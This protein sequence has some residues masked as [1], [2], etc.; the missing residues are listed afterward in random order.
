LISLGFLLLVAKGQYAAG[1]LNFQKGYSTSI[2]SPFELSNSTSR[3]ALTQAIV[4]NNSFFLTKTQAEFAAPDVVLHKGNFLS[5]FTPGVSFVAVPFYIIGKQIGVPQITTFL[6]TTIFALIN[7]ILISMLARK[8]GGG[9][10]TSIVSGL[11]FTFA[12]NALTYSQT[13]T[14][15]H[16]SITIILLTILLTLRKS[17]LVRNLLIGLFFGFGLLV[18]IPNSIMLTP[19][20][21]WALFQDLSL[22]NDSGKVSIGIRLNVIA[23]AIGLLPVIFGF[24]WYNTKTTGSPALLA[25]SVGRTDFFDKNVAPQNSVESPESK[26]ES[27]FEQKS[28]IP[29]NTRKE[30]N[31]IYTLLLSDER[32]W[33]Y[34]S[35][36]VLLGFIGYALSFRRKE[37]QSLI[38]VLT[39]IILT[40]VLIYSSFGDPWGGWAFGSRYLLPSTALVVAGLG[41]LL[42]KF[43]RNGLMWLILLPILLY[44]CGINVLGVMTTSAIP[45][46]VE[47]INLPQPIPYTYEYN[48][49]LIRSGFNSSLAYNYLLYDKI[50]IPIYLLVYFIGTSSLI[51]GVLFISILQKEVNDND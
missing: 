35:P 22:S 12:T 24:V 47:A 28:S 19:V 31:G 37:Q 46:K 15:H 7:L 27:P 10:W 18:D 6:M 29:F 39:S 49:Q 8:L 30:L 5:I 50:S 25:Q 3:Y 48:L 17:S 16:L 9:K 33:L 32:S 41:V 20:I 43:K 40:N 11:I 23:I 45:P 13:L 44:S 1:V 36:I 4:D 51:L 38:V 2:G 26:I 42:Q 34:Y 14:Q 21:I